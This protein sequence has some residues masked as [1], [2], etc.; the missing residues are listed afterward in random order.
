M[1]LKHLWNHNDRAAAWHLILIRTLISL[2]FHSIY[3]RH[4]SFD[5]FFSLVNIAFP[6]GLD[7]HQSSYRRLQH[8]SSVSELLFFFSHFK[9]SHK[10]NNREHDGRFIFDKG[11]TGLSWFASEERCFKVS[12][13]NRKKAHSRPA[14]SHTVMS[15]CLLKFQNVWLLGSTS[16]ASFR[17]A[18]MEGRCWR[19]QTVVMVREGRDGKGREWSIWSPYEIE[20]ESQET[21]WPISSWLSLSIVAFLTSK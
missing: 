4:H 14:H 18:S 8:S 7:Q 12:L 1:T 16:W 10:Q 13:L 19:T 6:A 11:C 9:A 3:E 15:L 17:S 2:T 5:I 20:R 21:K